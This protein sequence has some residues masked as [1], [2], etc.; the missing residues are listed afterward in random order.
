MCISQVP[1]KESITSFDWISAVS[2]RTN[3]LP[4]D[5]NL[6][7]S[8]VIL[9]Y[10]HRKHPV[11]TVKNVKKVNFPSI[12]LPDTLLLLCLGSLFRNEPWH[13]L[14]ASS[15]SEPPCHLEA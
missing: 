15:A 5:I 13:L 6:V 2:L 10:V 8:F 4:I 14:L 12:E 3:L 7:F 11:T 1:H 9:S